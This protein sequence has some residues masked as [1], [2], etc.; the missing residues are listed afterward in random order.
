VEVIRLTICANDWVLCKKLQK[1]Q[2]E[3]GKAFL[4]ALVG[5]LSGYTD[6]KECLQGSAAGCAWTAVGLIPYGKLKIAGKLGKLGEV[7]V[8]TARAACSFSGDTRVLMANGSTKPIKDVK[9]GDT[10]Q[11]TDPTTGE[12][13]ARKVTAVWVHDDHLVDLVLVNGKTLSTTEDHPFWNATDKQ[14]QPAKALVG[15]TV[16]TADHRQIAAVGLRQ[17]PVKLAPAHNITVDDLHTFYVLVGGVPVLVHNGA[18]RTFGFHDAPKVAGVYTITF[19]NGMT[20]V[21]SSTTDVHARIHAAFTDPRHAVY[22]G[23]YQQSD[24]VGISGNDM[25]GWTEPVIKAHEQSIINNYGGPAGGTLL[26]RINAVG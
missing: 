15:D 11:A 6:A 26:N 13:G 1:A 23:G 14:W 24:I 22:Q 17:S 19:N 16:L 3:A 10:V 2:D 4:L 9:V 18:C 20:Y 21:G 5:E 12:R 7:L 25:S 8:D